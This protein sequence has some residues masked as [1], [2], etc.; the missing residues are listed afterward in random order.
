[1]KKRRYKLFFYYLLLLVL[2]FLI[3]YVVYIIVI[4]SNNKLLFFTL[5]SIYF[6]NLIFNI[7]IFV[8]DRPSESKQSWQIIFVLIPLV[9]HILYIIFGQKYWNVMEI[10]EYKHEI[11]ENLSLEQYDFDFKKIKGYK[12]LRSLA[13]MNQKNIQPSQIITYDNG[14]YFFKELFKKIK[15]AKKFIFIQTYIIKPGEIFNQLKNILISKAHQ[16]V[17]IKILVDD[18]GSWDLPRDTFKELRE[19]GIKIERVEKIPFPFITGTSNYR[20]HRK[21]VIIDGETVL[22]GGCNISD[23]YAN[24]S[25]KYGVWQDSNIEI[26]GPNIDYYTKLFA[27]DW[28]KNTGEKI[29]YL[30]NYLKLYPKDINFENA[31]ISI[32]DGPACDY[33]FL[34]STMIKMFYE[35]KKTIKFATPYFVPSHRFLMTLKDVLSQGIEVTIYIPGLWDKSYVYYSTI[36]HLKPFIKYGLKVKVV[37][38]SF[39]HSKIAL[40]DDELAYLGTLNLDNRSFY[41]QFEITNFY[42]GEAVNDIK[43]LFAKYDSLHDKK[44]FNKLINKKTNIIKRYAFKIIEP[45]F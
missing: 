10:N 31:I 28:L 40:I 1:M 26:I 11:K 30:S 19:N 25:T 27:Y 23:E 33:P 35:A 44:T 2:L 3:S 4:N 41:S 8:Q 14:F 37:Q 22:T 7:I 29:N 15:S 17:E 24:F 12:K 39:L 9:G 38:N 32:E 16:S 43:H 5:I 36:S 20:T 42:I 18:F 34:E 13:V 21:Y 45:V 6:V